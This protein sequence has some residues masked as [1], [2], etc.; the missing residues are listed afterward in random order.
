MTRSP[1]HVY[2]P[3][4]TAIQTSEK[5]PHSI[6]E[7]SMFRVYACGVGALV[8]FAGGCLGLSHWIWI[9]FSTLYIGIYGW[10]LVTAGIMARLSLQEY[11]K[12]VDQRNQQKSGS[13]VESQ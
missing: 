9:E 1:T 12:V 13:I 8:L 6:R 11:K 5:M 2:P 10:H 4:I 3:S 7:P